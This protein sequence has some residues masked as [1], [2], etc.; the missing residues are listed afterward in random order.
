MGHIFDL[1]AAWFNRSSRG[2]GTVQLHGMQSRFRLP[3]GV[4]WEIAFVY[5]SHTGRW[6]EE[7]KTSENV[8]AIKPYPAARGMNSKSVSM[9]GHSPGGGVLDVR[10]GIR[11]AAE[12]LATSSQ[13]GL[14]GG[15]G[16]R[17]RVR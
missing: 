1:I 16:E 14:G 9:S 11:G 5:Y 8:I 3:T 4:P 10:G 17:S 2:C 15:H 12:F 7:A 13:G 6:L